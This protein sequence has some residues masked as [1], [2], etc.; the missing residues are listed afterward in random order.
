MKKET[1][2][3]IV[4]AIIA[5]IIFLIAGCD[6]KEEITYETNLRTYTTYDEMT[7]KDV[8]TIYYWDMIATR[9]RSEMLKKWPRVIFDP[10]H[11]YA[12][13]FI[14]ERAMA[15]GLTAWGL[16]MAGNNPPKGFGEAMIKIGKI[17]GVMATPENLMEVSKHFEGKQ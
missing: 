10:N 9:D 5:A 2:V 8:S 14:K 3:V 16:C 6:E 4:L 15:D 13:E 7:Q 12:G 17:V 1:I 11:E